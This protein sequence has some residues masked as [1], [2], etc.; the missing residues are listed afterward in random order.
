[1]MPKVVGYLSQNDWGSVLATCLGD[2]IQL[3]FSG[4]GIRS[5]SMCRCSEIQAIPI[6]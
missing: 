4:D 2:G 5:I 3:V 6:C 1:M